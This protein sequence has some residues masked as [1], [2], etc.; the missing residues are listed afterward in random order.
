MEGQRYITLSYLPCYSPVDRLLNLF[1]A[2]YQVRVSKHR[3]RTYHWRVEITM[4]EH[5]LAPHR[6]EGLP[7]VINDRH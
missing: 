6:C 4:H 5:K 3:D 7:L 2:G 1:I